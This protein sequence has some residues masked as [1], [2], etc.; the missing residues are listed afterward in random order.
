MSVGL[1]PNLN[2]CSKHLALKLVLNKYSL[3]EHR[4]EDMNKGV[5][6]QMARE[7][8][9]LAGYGRG[10]VRVGLWDYLGSRSKWSREG[11][12]CY[13]SSRKEEG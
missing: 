6:Q 7:E 10:K 8:G 13:D 3:N 5:N 1:V 4:N 12:S 2:L 11:K 9:P